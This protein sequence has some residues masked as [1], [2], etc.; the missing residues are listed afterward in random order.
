LFFDDAPYT[1]QLTKEANYY[2]IHNIYFNRLILS[3]C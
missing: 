1:Q 3:M 2:N